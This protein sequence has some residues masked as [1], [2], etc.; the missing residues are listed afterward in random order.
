M[1]DRPGPRYGVVVRWLAA[2]VILSSCA[3]TV[4]HA[5]YTH[6]MAQ[7]QATNE[8]A[9]RQLDDAK[10]RMRSDHVRWKSNLESSNKESRRRLARLEHALIREQRRIEALAPRRGVPA[11]TRRFAIVHRELSR[12]TPVEPLADGIRVAADRLFHAG[13]SRLI[14]TANPL[15]AAVAKSLTGLERRCAI[16]VHS[17]VIDG[18]DAWAIGTAQG[19]AIANALAAAGVDERRLIV[20]VFAATRPIESNDSSAG[21]ARNRR[22]EFDCPPN[23]N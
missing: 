15:L 4:P 7:T 10:T 16:C 18:R 21:R 11:S 17:D 14:P 20:E 23:D 3:A 19:E 9:L 2:T 13:S 22:I 1:F 8:A 5:E 6:E 12:S